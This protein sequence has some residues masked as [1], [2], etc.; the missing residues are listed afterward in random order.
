MKVDFKS[1]GETVRMARHRR[2]LTQHQLAALFGVS[3][4]LIGDIER[5]EAT[6]PGY[7]TVVTLCALLDLDD[8]P[9]LTTEGG[10]V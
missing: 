1:W 2:K 3:D 10:E 8:P 7:T 5:G 9:A 4:S 6:N